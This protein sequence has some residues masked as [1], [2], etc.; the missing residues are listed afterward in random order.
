MIEPAPAVRII[1]TPIAQLV[2]PEHVDEIAD[3][4]CATT[5]LAPEAPA[6]VGFEINCGVALATVALN[7][8]HITANARV[9]R[10][11]TVIPPC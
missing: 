1:Q 10:S 4:H 9:H 7:Q 2:E 11:A 5:E 6:L 8:I 3:G